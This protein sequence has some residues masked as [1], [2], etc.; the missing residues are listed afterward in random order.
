MAY[1]NFND[2]NLNFSCHNTQISNDFNANNSDSNS[3]NNSNLT[4]KLTNDISICDSNYNNSSN[5]HNSDGNIQIQEN[6]NNHNL[7][8]VPMQQKT[9][10]ECFNYNNNIPYNVNID[11]THYYNNNSNFNDDNII[12]VNVS[13][14]NDLKQPVFIDAYQ[15]NHNCNKNNNIACCDNSFQ[16]HGN[17]NYNFNKDTTQYSNPNIMT[18]TPSV[19]PRTNENPSFFKNHNCNH[20]N[21]NCE[22]CFAIFLQTSQQQQQQQFTQNNNFINDFNMSTFNYKQN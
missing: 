12:N 15:S 19:I 6:N 18:I 3:N 21:Q 14:Y 20:F 5:S 11:N 22:I 2:S 16:N 8:T 10:I 4:N 9:N 1:D 7:M 13:D 17:C